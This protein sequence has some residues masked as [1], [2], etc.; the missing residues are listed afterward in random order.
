MV[1]YCLFGSAALRGKAEDC[2]KLVAS[3]IFVVKG[4][5][6]TVNRK[7]TGATL[8]RDGDQI[9]I[10]TRPVNE[11]VVGILGFGLE[12]FD[13]ACVASQGE[14]EKL[15]LMKPT[16]RKRMVDSVVGLG[17][18]EDLAKWANDQALEKNREAI[19]RICVEPIPALAPDDYRPSSQVQSQIAEL[20]ALKSE[21]DRLQGFLRVE[22]PVP[23]QPEEKITL[24]AESIKDLADTQ[25]AQRARL[26]AISPQL[27]FLPPCSTLDGRAAKFHAGATR[28]L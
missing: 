1:R 24:P 25:D 7:N 4:N 5:T 17:V 28:G 14:L 23:K 12:V 15:G 9:A 6:Y 13:V 27:K 21:Y 8:L 22:R 26:A 2:K 10:G 18:I 3:L 16:E 11:K 20:T 19:E